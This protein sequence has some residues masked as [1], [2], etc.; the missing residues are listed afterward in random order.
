MKQ[1]ANVLM[2]LNEV[3]SHNSNQHNLNGSSC[4]YQFS[5]R[6]PRSDHAHYD[7][8]ATQAVHINENPCDNYLN[9][10]DS[11]H[12]SFCQREQF[13]GNTSSYVGNYVATDVSQNYNEEAFPYDHRYVVGGYEDHHRNYA[14]I[15]YPQQR[16]GLNDFPGYN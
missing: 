3:N 8:M 1:Y 2:L 4:Q 15:S 14:H 13:N 9:V 11:V 7:I 10:N 5:E 16:Y 6:E 12:N